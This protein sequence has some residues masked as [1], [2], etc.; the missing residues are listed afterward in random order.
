MREREREKPT[1]NI[2]PEAV[3]LQS[4]RAATYAWSRISMAAASSQHLRGASW[5]HFGRCSH[6]HFGHLPQQGAGGFA[7]PG[8]HASQSVQALTSTHLTGACGSLL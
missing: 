7:H 3:T 1:S 2:N 4:E 8:S 6:P 5:Q